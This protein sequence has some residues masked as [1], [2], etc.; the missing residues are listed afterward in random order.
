MLN[1][2]YGPGG[3]CKECDETHEHPL[4][5]ILEQIEIPDPEPTEQELAKISA[6]AKLKS[7]GLTDEE[8]QALLM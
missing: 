6:L 5:N 2:I 4:N 1:V 8:I 7:L 3:F